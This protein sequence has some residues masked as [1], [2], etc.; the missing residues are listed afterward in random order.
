MLS[1]I[2]LRKN[3]VA[4]LLLESKNLD[5]ICLSGWLSIK[6]LSLFCLNTGQIKLFRLLVP[7]KL[8]ATCRNLGICQCAKEGKMYF[9]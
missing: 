7:N 5:E 6:F 2:K 4:V 1:R 9:R 8:M 3:V